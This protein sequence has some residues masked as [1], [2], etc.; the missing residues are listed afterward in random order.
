MNE[1]LFVNLYD[2][3]EAHRYFFYLFLDFEHVMCD[4]C[5]GILNEIPMRYYQAQNLL[6]LLY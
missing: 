2:V 1:R 4:G 3:E 6:D 5:G